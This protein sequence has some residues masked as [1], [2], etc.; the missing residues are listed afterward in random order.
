M[1]NS[2][3]TVVALGVALAFGGARAAVEGAAVYLFDDVT[4]LT[5]PDA[6]GGGNTGFLDSGATTTP[7]TPFL[8]S[9]NL[10]MFLDGD[11]DYMDIS[12][13]N[14]GALAT[15]PSTGDGDLTFEAFI[16]PRDQD[17]GW[18]F[19]LSR[20]GGGPYYAARLRKIGG[21][22]K[23]EA[24]AT[25]LGV[26]DSILSDPI[27][28]DTWTHVAFVL[29]RGTGFEIYTGGTL[30]DTLSVPQT[31]GADPIVSTVT[32]LGRETNQNYF[33]GL[34]DEVRFTAGKLDSTTIW[35][36]SQNTLNPEPGDVMVLST[37]VVV[38][39]AA[40]ISFGSVTGAT[41]RLES[42]PD[43]VSSNFSATGAFTIG[44][45]GSM[46]LFD[47]AGTSTSKNYRV[48]ASP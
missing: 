39:D 2:V 29:N 34:M 31:G 33:K 23:V 11:N 45:G 7:D 16:K 48:V 6:S 46:T 28:V 41:Y 40:G 47:P 10:S 35:H 24:F 15:F 8:Y 38:A 27:P 9:G 26:G 42:T 1:K 18:L 20:A 44:S 32:H 5:V 17:E 37:N 19:K 36:D 3:I 22:L 21:E 43:L 25:A 12:V 4:G 30:D 13:T 14:G